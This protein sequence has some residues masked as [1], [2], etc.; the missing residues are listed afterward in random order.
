MRKGDGELR[1]MIYETKFSEANYQSIHQRT[2]KLITRGKMGEAEME[3]GKMG[4]WGNLKIRQ[5]EILQ[6]NFKIAS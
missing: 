6:I 1:I 4:Q 3:K 5:F 2:A